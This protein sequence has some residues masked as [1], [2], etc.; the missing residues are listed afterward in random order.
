MLIPTKEIAK[1]FESLLVQEV[2]ELKQQGKQPLLK[3]ILVGNASEQLSFVAIKQKKAAKLGINFDF[4]HLNSNPLLY[5]E[6]INTV[7]HEAQKPETTGIIIQQPLPA[8]LNSDSMYKYIPQVKEIEGHT[9]KSQFMSP[10]GLAVLTCL[11]YTFTQ[12][13]DEKDILITDKDIP[14]FHKALKGK[15]VLLMGKG[16]TGGQPIAKT[17]SHM[18][19]NFLNIFSGT[20]K[21]AAD[22]FIKEA[23]VIITAVGKKVITRD[24]IKPG[25]VLL[26]VGLRKDETTETLKGDYDEEEI[27]DIASYY[28]RTPGGIGPIDVLYLYQNLIDAARFQ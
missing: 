11:K 22:L 12:S 15:R 1:I 27:A 9:P 16:V 19:I 25:A 18:K 6:F 2:S 10:L 24:A 3:T 14:F 8:S 23:D 20:S 21:D 28:T 5:E 13:M 26:N 4:I 17:L 7:K